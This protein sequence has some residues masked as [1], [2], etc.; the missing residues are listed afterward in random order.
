[1]SISARKVYGGSNYDY[2]YGICCDS[3]YVYVVGETASEGAGLYDALILKLNIADLS[4]NSRRRV[5]TSYND[6]FLGVSVDDDY[7]YAVGSS[8][9]SAGRKSTLVARFLITNL[10][11]NEAKIIRRYSNT[12]PYGS[13]GVVCLDTTNDLLYIVGICNSPEEP[14][15]YNG[16]LVSLA[17][18]FGLGFFS[19][20]PAYYSIEDFSI[21]VVTSGLTLSDSALTLSDS[22]LTLS[23]SALTLSD[24][25]LTLTDPYW[26]R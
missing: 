16:F 5:G 10:S 23:D 14:S 26:I 3:S 24:S 21:T 12:Y 22:A 13:G 17:T 25:A 1:L 8:T 2:L 11:T 15:G 4:I 19:S 7:I 18:G 6:A 9:D 20:T